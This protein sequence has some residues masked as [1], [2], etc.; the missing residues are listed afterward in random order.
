MGTL[1]IKDNFLEK[2]L[3][4]FLYDYFLKIP[5]YYGHNS[6]EGGN[7][8]YNHEFYFD[9]PLINFL[10]SLFE[11]NIKILRVYTNI[12]Y[13]DMDG[14]F[15]IDSG[16]TTYLLMISNTLQKNSGAFQFLDE[17]NKINSINFVKNRMIQFPAKIKHRGLAP[18]EK[19][20]PRITLA[21]KTVKL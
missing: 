6:K 9:N 8:F 16:D 4:N 14:E 17:E 1:I 18:I 15:H 3:I 12:Q 19:N 21:F 10:C 7:S 20:L 13:N 11:K 2:N 5:H